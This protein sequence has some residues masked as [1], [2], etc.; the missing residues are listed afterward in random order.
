MSKENPFANSNVIPIGYGREIRRQQKREAGMDDIEQLVQ[1]ITE[2][3]ESLFQNTAKLP[4]EIRRRKSQALRNR[5]DGAIVSF[6]KHGLGD[7]QISQ[8]AEIYRQLESLFFE[9]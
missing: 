6:G 5:I 3:A 4:I 7:G 2:E 1:S 9:E 8:L